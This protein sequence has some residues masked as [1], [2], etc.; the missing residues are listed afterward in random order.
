MRV[1]EHGSQQQQLVTI[2]PTPCQNI[3]KSNEIR[4]DFHL[5]IHQTT[6]LSC[7]EDKAVYSGWDGQQRRVA[8]EEEGESGPV[9]WWRLLL[10]FGN[11]I[12]VQY[13]DC[14]VG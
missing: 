12:M 4:A 14:G 10:L 7:Q 1:D 13:W 6:T 11:Y 5:A 3:Y 8:K 2:T 9:L